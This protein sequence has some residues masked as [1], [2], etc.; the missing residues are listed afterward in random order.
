MKQVRTHCLGCTAQWP[1]ADHLQYTDPNNSEV[2][3]LSS[4]MT[5]ANKPRRLPCVTMN[6]EKRKNLTN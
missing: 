2:A 4:P 6:G 3:M 5:I 1:N